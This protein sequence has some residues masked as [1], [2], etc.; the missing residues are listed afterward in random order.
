M[1]YRP[2]DPELYEDEGEDDD[3]LDEEGRARLK[4]KVPPYLH[5]MEWN[6]SIVVTLGPLKAAVIER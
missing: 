1:S 6:L 5:Q 4:L 2:F 3:V